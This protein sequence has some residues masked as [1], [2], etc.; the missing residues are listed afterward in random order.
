M[1]QFVVSLFG[2][3]E[4]VKK[5]IIT[6]VLAVG[7]LSVT[8]EGQAWQAEDWQVVGNTEQTWLV[9][10]EQ[11]IGVAEEQKRVSWL[12]LREDLYPVTEDFKFQ[13]E[14][15]PVQGTDHNLIW[16]FIDEQN[17]YQAHLNGGAIWVSRFADGQESLSVAKNFSINLSQSYKLE[18]IEQ[19]RQVT[20][21]IDDQP[22][23]DF[24]DWTSDEQSHGQVGFKLAPGAII[25]V[26]SKF[27]NVRVTDPKQIILPVELLKQTDPAWSEL[28]Y[29]TADLWSA[30]PTVGRWG[31]ALTSLT[32]I[33]RFY[34][35][36]LMPDGSPTTPAAI[37]SWL[38]TQP[39][40]YLGQGLVNWWAGTRLISQIST[41]YSTPTKTLPKLEFAYQALD[42]STR[43]IS[44]LTSGRPAIVQ[45]P[46][47]F[48]VAHGFNLSNNDFFIHDPFYDFTQ[49]SHHKQVLSLRLFTPSQTDLSAIVVVHRPEVTVTIE[50]ESGTA[51]TQTWSEWL[52]SDPEKE[53]TAPWQFTVIDK[54][55]TGTYRFLIEGRQEDGDTKVLI[56]DQQ[57]G[58]QDFTPAQNQTGNQ[59]LLDFELQFDK[60]TGAVFVNQFSWSVFL[61]KLA[62]AYQTGLIDQ[63][64][65]N[66]LQTLALTAQQADQA[67]WSRY[68][69]YLKNIL[70]I[71]KTP[72]TKEKITALQAIL[73]E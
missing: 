1:C 58:V 36:D 71:I 14:F 9:E 64:K 39:D 32:M 50:H 33:M 48:I 15:V 4:G 17:Y 12:V 35:L 54:P 69:T 10:E 28:I 21:L 25:P 46:G 8:S 2:F 72:Q 43:L 6:L 11:I 30:K 13:F 51:L 41:Q 5:L 34:G 59:E 45:V 52:A 38:L 49:L 44:E 18:I 3:N 62:N 53:Q 70:E 60:T 20:I 24:T 7:W 66:R 42:W 56:Y 61:A 40:G 31:C 29:D 26:E 67:T 63:L 47:H 19:G 55:M 73:A 16:N 68:Q 57:A 27:T 37:N 22:I 65:F 23:I